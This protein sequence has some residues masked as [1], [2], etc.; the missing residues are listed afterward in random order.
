MVSIF[1]SQTPSITD[2]TDATAYTLG[3]SFYVTTGAS[4]TGARWYFPATLPGGTVTAALWT[5]EPGAEG[6]LLASKAFSSPVAGEWNTVTWDTPV[7]LTANIEYIVGI[8]TPDRYVATAG[9]FTS[10]GVTNGII[11]AIQ[12]N[13]EVPSGGGNVRNGRLAVNASPTFPNTNGSGACYFADVV[14]A[15]AAEVFGAAA[16]DLGPLT[17]TITGTRRVAGTLA[18]ALGDLTA[19]IVGQRTI[20]GVLTADLGPLTAAAAGQRTVYGAG[21]AALGPL[22]ATIAGAQPNVPATSAAT[23]GAGRT[24]T[25]TVTARRTSAPTVTGG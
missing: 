1:T 25:A 21:A 19:T 16:A 10:A 8:H 17:A 18:V 23:V 3:T 14:I 13:T 7:S 9:F 4:C 24:S 12:D 6:T 22:T 20:N 5:D 11:T 15:S 2:A